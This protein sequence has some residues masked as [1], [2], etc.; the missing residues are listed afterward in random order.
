MLCVVIGYGLFVDVMV[1]EVLDMI[2]LNTHITHV[3]WSRGRMRFAMRTMTG[4]RTTLTARAAIVT[5]PLGVLAAPFRRDQ[6][7]G[8]GHDPAPLRPACR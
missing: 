5:L 3:Q 6:L 8:I 7:A 2:H 4:H 1:V